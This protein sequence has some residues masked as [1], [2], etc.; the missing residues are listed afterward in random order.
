MKQLVLQAFEVSFQNFIEYKRWIIQIHKGKKLCHYIGRMAKMDKYGLFFYPN[1]WRKKTAVRHEEAESWK[2]PLIK[3]ADQ[4]THQ[5]RG[6]L[7]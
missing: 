4:L 1:M 7:Q 3:F 2:K 6:K 5:G